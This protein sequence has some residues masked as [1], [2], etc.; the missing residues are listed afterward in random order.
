MGAGGCGVILA[1]SNRR[2]DGARA[3]SWKRVGIFGG[4][5][6]LAFFILN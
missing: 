6:G 4:L 1:W 3:F 5:V 2:V